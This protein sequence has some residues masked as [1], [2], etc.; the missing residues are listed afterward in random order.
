MENTGRSDCY[1]YTSGYCNRREIASLKC[2]G[3]DCEWWTKDIPAEYWKR[4][5]WSLMNAL[6]QKVAK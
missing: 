2:T 5:Y 1:Y 4:K 6:R 3:Q